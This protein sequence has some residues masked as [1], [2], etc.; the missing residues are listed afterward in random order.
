MTQAFFFPTVV[1]I[2]KAVP[3]IPLISLQFTSDLSCP[4]VEVGKNCSLPL[5]YT[6]HHIYIYSVFSSNINKATIARW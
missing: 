1:I 5:V 2:H 6:V 3:G 4:L